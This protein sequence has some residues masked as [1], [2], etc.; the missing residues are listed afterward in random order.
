LCI[1]KI[2]V[3]HKPPYNFSDRFNIRM[4]KNNRLKIGYVSS[5]FG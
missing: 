1:E 3:L 4:G 2:Q 5:D